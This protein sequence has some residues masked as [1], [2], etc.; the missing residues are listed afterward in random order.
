[1]A[2]LEEMLALQKMT[3]TT[4]IQTGFEGESIRFAQFLLED[5]NKNIP[6]MFL[7]QFWSFFDI[8]PAL[9]N[10]TDQDCALLMHDLRIAILNYKM[11]LPDFQKSYSDIM[12][13]DQLETKFFAKIKRSTGGVNRERALQATQIRQ[14]LTGDG[15]SS[16]RGGILSRIGGMFKGRQ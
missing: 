4:P 12:Y 10:L 9:T 5:H 14:F 1:M 11:S 8:E 13:L 16:A 15:E 3:E 7:K 2:S 6:E